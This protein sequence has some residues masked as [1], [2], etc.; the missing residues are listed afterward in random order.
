[1]KL[2]L[3]NGLHQELLR[4]LGILRCSGNVK[5]SLRLETILLLSDNFKDF[6]IEK[7]S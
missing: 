4:T 7:A 5:F 3:N 6:D 1:M 2:T